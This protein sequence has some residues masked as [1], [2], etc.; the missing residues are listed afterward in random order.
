MHRSNHTRTCH[1]C[2]RVL[3]TPQSLSRHLERRNPCKPKKNRTSETSATSETSETFATYAKR[4]KCPHC[5]QSFT[6]TDNLQRHIDHRCPKLK[7]NNVMFDLKKI[8][9][10]LRT[11]LLD[12]LRQEIKDEPRVTNNILQVVC[13]GSNDNYLDML[14]D[15]IGFDNALEYIKNCALSDINGDIKLIE[16]IYFEG[17]NP[18]NYPIRFLDKKRGALEFIDEKNRT[19]A[20]TKGDILSRRLGNN[21]Q[22]TYLKSV[23]YLITSN[24]KHKKCPNVFL[25][26]YDIMT[27]NQH[28]YELSDSN[29]QKKIIKILGATF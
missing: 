9:S 16:K 21:L 20:D 28:I 18:G 12:Q 27:W 3:A 4:Y 24:L 5:T 22:N 1:R 14:T 17:S 8:K 15:T 13:V 6:R 11:E 26:E 2:G 23:N 10:D 29:R 25:D 7:Q 19:V